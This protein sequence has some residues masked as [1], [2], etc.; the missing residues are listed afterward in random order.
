M[1]LLDLFC[2]AGGCA[3]GYHRAGF[4]DITGVDIRPMPRYPFRFIQADALEFLSSVQPGEYDLIHCSPPCQGYSQLRHL[5]WLKDKEY[6][7][8]I[9]P[10]RELLQGIGAPWVIENAP[11]SPLS[12]IILCG[13]MFG[14]PIYRHRRFECSH[15]LFSPEHPRHPEVIGHGRRLNDRKKKGTLNAG[16]GKGAWGRSPI[17][18]VAGGQFRKAEGERAMGIDWMLKP[19]LAQAIPPAYTEWIGRQMLA[20]IGGA[21]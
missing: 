14:L 18:T 7:L 9:A 12:G 20:Q 17:V 6:P 2:G 13:Q 1:R 5:P 15:V 19:E 3:V 10:V 4:T 11:T 16:S 8:L 21:Q